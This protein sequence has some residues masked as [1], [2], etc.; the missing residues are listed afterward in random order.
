MQHVSPIDD[1]DPAQFALLVQLMLEAPFLLTRAVLPGTVRA[2]FGRII[3]MS[4]VHGLRHRRRRGR[5]PRRRDRRGGVA[6]RPHR[7]RCAGRTPPRHR[8]PRQQCGRAARQP[9]R[10]LRPRPVRAPRAADARGALP[11]DPR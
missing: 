10:R 3:N 4:S 11:A 2:G 6:G 7:P 1:F 8:H 9:D 5:S